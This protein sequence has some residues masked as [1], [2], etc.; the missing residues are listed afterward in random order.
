MV[1]AARRGN[2]LYYT[3]FFKNQA[4][5]INAK[6]QVKNFFTAFITYKLN[7]GN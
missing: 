7:Y 2:F 5:N 3:L 4:L 1:N 6:M